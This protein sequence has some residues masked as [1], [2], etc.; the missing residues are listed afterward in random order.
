LRYED[1]IDG[2]ASEAA[3]HAFLRALHGLGRSGLMPSSTALQ[4]E[5][6]PEAVDLVHPAPARV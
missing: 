6:F 1:R 5:V 3:L 2:C 4:A